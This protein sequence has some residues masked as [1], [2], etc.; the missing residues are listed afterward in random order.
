MGRQSSDWSHSFWHLLESFFNKVVV[1]LIGIAFLYLIDSTLSL[2][3]LRRFSALLYV[4]DRRSKYSLSHFLSIQLL[5]WSA[6]FRE[7]HISSQLPW[8]FFYKVRSNGLEI[9]VKKLFWKFLD[10]S[11]PA[12]GSI[13]ESWFQFKM[14]TSENIL[15]LGNLSYRGSSICNHVL[16]M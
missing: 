7:Q 2:E 10:I 9:F 1:R 6:H 13:F 8:N 11:Q 4:R 14:H 12:I 16:W 3:I 15:K 5:S